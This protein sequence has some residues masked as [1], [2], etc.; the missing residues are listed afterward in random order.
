MNATA[1]NAAKLSDVN[2]FGG[3]VTV[4]VEPRFP[5]NAWRLF[6]DPA[7]AD[8]V[9]IGYLDGNIGPKVD[10][11]EGWSTLG[12]EFRCVLDFGCGISDWRGTHLNAG[13]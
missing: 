4:H 9:T 1:I 8:V 12:V 2:P 3:R 11:R 13:A 10:V 6:A 7:E 5:G